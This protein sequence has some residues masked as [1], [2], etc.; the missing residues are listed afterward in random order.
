MFGF[1][2]ALYNITLVT[3]RELNSTVV[4]DSD[5]YLFIVTSSDERC[6][7]LLS[8]YVVVGWN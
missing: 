3:S 8:S 5:F 7:H 6:L 4:R 2:G 1:L